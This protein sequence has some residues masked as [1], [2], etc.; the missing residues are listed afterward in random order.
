MKR[1]LQMLVSK[2][3]P[4]VTFHDSVAGSL[5]IACKKPTST[6]SI[7]ANQRVTAT[8]LPVEKNKSDTSC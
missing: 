1:K 6:G 5:I 7:S 2:G 4:S 3:N 8:S